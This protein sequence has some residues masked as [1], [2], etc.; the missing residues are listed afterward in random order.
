MK[1]NRVR[2]RL[3]QKELLAR[4]DGSF[5]INSFGLTDD[6]VQYNLIRQYGRIIGKEYIEKLTPVVEANTNAAATCKYH[7]IGASNQ[8]HTQLPRLHAKANKLVEHQTKASGTLTITTV[9][10]STNVTVFQQ[11]ANA[12][13]T[14]S[15][16]LRDSVFTL[17]MRHDQF[18][19]IN[20]TPVITEGNIATYRMLATGAANTGGG[21]VDFQISIAPPLL[22]PSRYGNGRG[23]AV[24]ESGSS[25]TAR[26]YI[27]VKGLQ[28]GA[29]Y[30]I[31][32]IVTKS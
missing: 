30:L 17:Q 3:T 10:K 13:A 23:D 15:D 21:T 24:N 20:Q 12:A 25:D 16:D 31:E 9:D 26:G 29:K 22:D 6:E 1:Q 27:K 18:Q 28:S 8:K 19:I 14:V 11:M 2:K 32:T 4:F 5:Q 7:L